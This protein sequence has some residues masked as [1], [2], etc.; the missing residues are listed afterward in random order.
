MV[1]K[2]YTGPISASFVDIHFHFPHISSVSSLLTPT[3]HHMRWMGKIVVFPT[4]ERL[5]LSRQLYDYQVHCVSIQILCIDNIIPYHLDLGLFTL[6]GCLGW[7]EAP[8]VLVLLFCFSG[9]S[10]PC[11]ITT[12]KWDMNAFMPTLIWHE[13][14]FSAA[15]AGALFVQTDRPAL[16]LAL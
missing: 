11:I 7:C 6:N 10:F 2:E 9:T 8:I 15:T 3:T 13:C 1:F 4:C 12:W 16:L 14:G 5:Q